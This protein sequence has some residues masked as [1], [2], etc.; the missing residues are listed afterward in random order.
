[1]RGDMAFGGGLV[2]E[3]DEAMGLW[4]GENEVGGNL[5]RREG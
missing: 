1:M 2:K 3:A 5:R 4:E